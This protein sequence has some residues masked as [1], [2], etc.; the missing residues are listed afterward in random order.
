MGHMRQHPAEL[1]H[2]DGNG[3]LEEVDMHVEEAEAIDVKPTKWGKWTF[4]PLGF[5]LVYDESEYTVSLDFMTDSAHMLNLIMQAQLRKTWTA[6]D[7]GQLVKALGNVLQP[8]LT[9]SLGD[10]DRKINP[11]EV[12]RLNGYTSAY[13]PFVIPDLS[14]LEDF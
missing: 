10:K 9:M 2:L 1:G 11:R 5:K 6:E 12:A 7:I 13:A 14:D 3:P 8:S 4:V